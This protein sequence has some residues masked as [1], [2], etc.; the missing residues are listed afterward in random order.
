M[1]T[2]TLPI[3]DPSFNPQEER[4]SSA[5]KEFMTSQRPDRPKVLDYSV[6]FSSDPR[7]VYRPLSI[8]LP[9]CPEINHRMRACLHSF[10]QS[11]SS[12]PVLLPQISGKRS[13]S[14]STA[15]LFSESFL[16]ETPFDKEVL[17]RDI[18]RR[19][20][21]TGLHVGGY[22]ELRQ[23]WTYGDLKPRTY[24]AFGGEAYRASKYI[25]DIANL[26]VNSFNET[27]FKSRFSY[28]DVSLSPSKR[29][30]TYDYQT[31]TTN[32]AEQK[33][34]LYS[35]SEYMKGVAI[36]VL[37]TR[38]GLITIDVG[39]MLEEYTRITT[40]RPEFTI[41]QLF[42]DEDYTPYRHLVA[43]FL[44]VYGNISTA[45]SLHGMHAAQICG[46]STQSKCVGDD[47]LASGDS[48]PHPMSFDDTLMAV[49]SLGD[50]EETKVQVWEDD[51]MEYED[52]DSQRGWHYTKRPIDR[53]VNNIVIG[54][55]IEFPMFGAL[56]PEDDGVHSGEKDLKTRLRSAATQ[57][58]HL[59]RKVRDALID[60]LHEEDIQ[61]L[62]QS[63]EPVYAA[64]DIPRLGVLPHERIHGIRGNLFL[65]IDR[66]VFFEAFEDIQIGS[67]DPSEPV[68]IPVTV[69]LD[70]VPS[71][72]F[73]VVDMEYTAVVDRFHRF[74]QSMGYLVATPLF[75]LAFVE[76][77]EYLR[78]IER[79]LNREV[80]HV[81]RVVVL[82][83]PHWCQDL[84]SRLQLTIDE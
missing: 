8:Y 27:G 29:L 82:D 46:P 16:P 2:R 52:N 35:L 13:V 10:K 50:I 24:F 75:E 36:E 22:A 66:S 80:L 67:F 65:P 25:K 18:E 51:G 40:D 81:H 62:L 53:I 32:F 58:F 12:L 73:L 31:F 84:A 69:G 59:V 45:T 56:F 38:E 19:Y 78:R 20:A 44:G 49:R 64:F 71:L 30:F 4:V 54:L 83:V 68:S 5:L 23:V 42:E 21:D 1:L 74:M 43:G 48:D 77:A 7:D 14:R 3:R 61:F 72:P 47:V 11:V 57:T 28:H 41:Q 63:M 70:R 55:L 33:Y 6:W 9:P 76:Y 17:P 26:L 15:S 37:D 39:E 60:D 34:F 79:Y